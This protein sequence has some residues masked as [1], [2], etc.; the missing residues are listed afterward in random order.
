MIDKR[1]ILKIVKIENC[2]S[3]RLLLLR[4]TRISQKG[5]IYHTQARNRR[6]TSQPEIIWVLSD[7]GGGGAILLCNL[8]MINKGLSA[9]NTNICRGK[10]RLEIE[11]LLSQRKVIHKLKNDFVI[12][13]FYSKG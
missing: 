5:Q 2:N 6:I 3:R 9:L 11:E 10:S 12:I 1:K 7:R 8:N 13:Q 4:T